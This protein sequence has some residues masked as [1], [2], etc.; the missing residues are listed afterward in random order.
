MSTTPVE[1]QTDPTAF[2]PMTVTAG[3]S[4]PIG[5]ELEPVTKKITLDKARIYEGWPARRSRHCDYDA[6]HATGLPAP[7]INGALVAGVLGELFIKFFGENYVGGTLSFNLT[8][9][10]QLDDELTAR[11]VVKDKVAEAGGTRLVLDVWLENQNGDKVLVGS[12]SGLA[13]AAVAARQGGSPV[14]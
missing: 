5:F 8:R 10:V 6:A 1:F 11:G 2:T 9:Q 7:N 3:E 14:G 12:A 13:P 4:L